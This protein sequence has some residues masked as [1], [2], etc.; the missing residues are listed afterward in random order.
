MVKPFT[1]MLDLFV[2]SP[3]L[4]LFSRAECPE[5][6]IFYIKERQGN[7]EIEF[8]KFYFGLRIAFL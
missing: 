4:E 1:L 7:S 8:M 3:F 5:I 2:H 6:T